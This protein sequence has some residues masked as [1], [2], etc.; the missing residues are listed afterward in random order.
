MTG[1]AGDATTVGMSSPLAVVVVDDDVATANG[2][3][4][5]IGALGHKCAVAHDGASA[6]GLIERN[7]ADV[8]VS[9]LSMP[10]IDGLELCR[11]LRVRK[12]RYV[13]FVLVSAAG[14]KQHVM[15]AMHAGVDDYLTKPIDLDA[16]EARMVCAERVVG[17]HRALLTRNKELRRDSER[18]LEVSRVD[19]LT[20]ARNRR[21]LTEDLRRVHGALIRYGGPYAVAMCDVDR[22]KDYNDH[23]GHLAGDEALKSVVRTINGGLR[24]GDAVYR[25]GGEELVILLPHQSVA[26]A[27]TAMERIRRQVARMTPVTISIGVSEMLAQDTDQDACIRRA[28]AALY[29]A[30][31]TGR[32]RV[33]A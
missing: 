24:R 9:D 14:D 8:V 27:S 2:F 33:V 23:H 10:G 4:H 15:D 29:R 19:A 21:A 7:H 25:Y 26:A 6:L 16:L 22:F 3:C 12:D 30:K 31:S 11:A 17:M 1:G 28:D 20:G 5:A 13:Y 32:N 18:Y